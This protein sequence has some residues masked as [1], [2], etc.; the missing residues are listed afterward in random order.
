[1]KIIL[2]ILLS[3]ILTFSLSACS[4]SKKKNSED[5]NINKSVPTDKIKNVS[6][7]NEDT[8]PF[9]TVDP[10]LEEIESEIALLKEQVIQ[11]QSQI[12]CLC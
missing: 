4:S 12:C 9:Y 1:M 6:L 3:L 11:Y 10:K 5:S 2:N 8:K 7:F